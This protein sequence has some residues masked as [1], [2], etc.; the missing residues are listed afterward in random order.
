MV[1]FHALLSDVSGSTR[2]FMQTVLSFVHNRLEL[3]TVELQEEKYRIINLVIWTALTVLF[4]FLAIIMT[5]FAIIFLMEDNN[6][7]I[8]LV[9][10]ALVY[11]LGAVS[12]FLV[13]KAK[14]K[15]GIPFAQTLRELKKD[16][17][18]F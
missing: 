9:V 16:S 14:L 8:A 2:E 3:L 4:S 12:G 17:E 10:F 6:R 5:T 15:K 11:I 7:I 13:I 1:D 18:C